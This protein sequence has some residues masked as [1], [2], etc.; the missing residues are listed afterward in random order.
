MLTAMHAV[1]AQASSPAQQGVHASYQPAATTGAAHAS[2]KA[3]AGVEVAAATRAAVPALTAQIPVCPTEASAQ[4]AT[5]DAIARVATVGAATPNFKSNQLRASAAAPSSDGV[6]HDCMSARQPA[7]GGGC[8]AGGPAAVQ[9]HNI[10]DG[11]LLQPGSAFARS[12]SVIA[13]QQASQQVHRIPHPSGQQRLLLN[14]ANDG[15]GSVGAACPAQCATHFTLTPVIK[16]TATSLLTSTKGA[17]DAVPKY[18]HITQNLY[19]RGVHKPQRRC[20]DDVPVCACCTSFASCLAGVASL[21][22]SSRQQAASKVRQWCHYTSTAEVLP[23]TLDAA[24]VPTNAFGPSAK[25]CEPAVQRQ[26]VERSGSVAETASEERAA[27]GSFCLNR[28][29]FIFCDPQSCP[30]GSNCSNKY[31]IFPEDSAH[32]CI[33]CIAVLGCGIMCILSALILL[34]HVYLN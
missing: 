25:S 24:S 30:Y 13:P 31:A 20:E 21:R 19:T 32:Q 28:Q 15:A 18:R 16:P 29:L 12:A 2:S 26:R 34:L 33:G 7:A 9:C 1:Q 23:N 11:S 17:R 10:S 14:Q 8:E 4:F 22:R 6:P 5:M 27:C 3:H